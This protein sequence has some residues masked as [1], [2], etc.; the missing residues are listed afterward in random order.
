MYVDKIFVKLEK[1]ECQN[2]QATLS[3]VNDI[4]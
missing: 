2:E 3:I 4:Q 1:Y